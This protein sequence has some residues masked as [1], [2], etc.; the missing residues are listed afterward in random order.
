[1][2]RELRWLVQG[3]TG[4]WSQR[5]DLKPKSDSHWDALWGTPRSLGLPW[6][7][8][9]E[10]SACSVGDLSSIPWLGRS[11]GE[12]NGYPVQYSG[13]ENSMDC[14]ELDTRVTC[15][16]TFFSCS[17]WVLEGTLEIARSAI[18][19]PVLLFCLYLMIQ[20]TTEKAFA[21]K[22]FNCIYLSFISGASLVAQLVK[23]LPAMQETPDW[24][25]GWED[26]LEKGGTTHSSIL[27]IHSMKDSVQSFTG[28]ARG[29]KFK[30]HRRAYGEK[31][32]ALC[33][34]SPAI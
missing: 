17:L 31:R 34:C 26:L 30:E 16:F 4:S 9:W 1:M 28:K 14:K 33:S 12:G 19:S 15:T 29:M 6:W 20:N 25:L 5:V 3:S 27:G 23:N 2:I 13:L 22:K 21:L 10:E 7:L 18:W 24:F 32:S 8:S 11:P